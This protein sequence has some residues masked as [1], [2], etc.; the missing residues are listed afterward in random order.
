MRRELPCPG[1]RESRGTRPCFDWT[2]LL[3]AAWYVKW[4]DEPVDSLEPR[5]DRLERSVLQLV[6]AGGRAAMSALVDWLSGPASVGREGSPGDIAECCLTI[7]AHDDP[8]AVL[9]ALCT[10]SRLSAS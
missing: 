2:A 8:G 7:L 3:A 4:R 1:E 9:E 6:R 10:P 5:L